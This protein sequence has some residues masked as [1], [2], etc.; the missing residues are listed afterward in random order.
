MH[1]EAF[2]TVQAMLLPLVTALLSVVW[3]LGI[4]GWLGQPMDTWSAM[5]PV[6]ILAIAAGHA[7]QILKRYYEE[8]A[9][10]RDS[11][12]AVV[13]S[14]VAVGPVMLIA[15]CIAA[16]GFASLITFGITSVR[17]FG[18]LLASGIVSALIIEM[19]FTPACRCLLPAPKTP[20]A[21]AREAARAGSTVAST[22]WVGWS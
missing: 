22:C 5:T 11:A 13:R 9:R 19:T 21:A 3:A 1:Y 12:E 7:V 10:T 8:Y 16:A 6:L 18:L 17:A 15:G 2:R 4:M 20:R 14:I